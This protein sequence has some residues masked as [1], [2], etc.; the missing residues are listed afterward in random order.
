MLRFLL[1]VVAAPAPVGLV[2]A[3]VR[4]LGCTRLG[5]CF[6]EP[7]PVAVVAHS[8]S[9]NR[10]AVEQLWRL[11]QGMNAAALLRWDVVDAQAVLLGDGLLAGVDVQAVL[12]SLG[13]DVHR[14]LNQPD[15][16]AAPVLVALAS[17]YGS[18]DL[19]DRLARARVFRP[20]APLCLIT[21]FTE[22]VPVRDVGPPAPQYEDA[23][24]LLQAAGIAFVS[25]YGP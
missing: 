4:E 12:A 23:R 16:D 5:W 10:S 24:A 19:Q 13:I 21:G 2:D 8:T 25:T 11:R 1:G 3:P 20:L 9:E 17:A 15:L 14:G 7:V 18:S 6:L 22:S